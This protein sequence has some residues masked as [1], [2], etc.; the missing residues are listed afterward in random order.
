M[1]NRGQ[2]CPFLRP[3]SKAGWR[4]S[5]E[6]KGGAGV[7]SKWAVGTGEAMGHLDEPGGEG[8]EAGGRGRQER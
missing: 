7:I 8:G 1:G 6:G 2:R 3:S 4:V 5:C